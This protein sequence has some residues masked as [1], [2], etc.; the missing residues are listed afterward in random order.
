MKMLL[1]IK[2]KGKVI[3][4]LVELSD[5]EEKDEDESME[6]SKLKQILCVVF[7]NEND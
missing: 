4:R 6:E 7:S 1:P 3:P 5:T 2:E